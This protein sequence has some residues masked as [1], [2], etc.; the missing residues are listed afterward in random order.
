MHLVA[1]SQA[2]CTGARWFSVPA[3][4]LESTRV[5]SGIGMCFPDRRYQFKTNIWHI[6][7]AYSDGKWWW[8]VFEDLESCGGPSHASA[9]DASVLW[10]AFR[11]FLFDGLD[12]SRMRGMSGW[13][14]V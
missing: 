1:R 11:H 4:R 13:L 2:P 7:E 3:I 6:R 10:H 9:R 14:V 5:G 12:D 8:G